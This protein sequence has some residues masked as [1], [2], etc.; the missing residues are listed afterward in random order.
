MKILNT[1]KNIVFSLFSLLAISTGAQVSI[2][3]GAPTIA[4]KGLL[5][6]QN[7]TAGIVYP[8]FELTATDIEAPVENPDGSGSS[9]PGPLFTTPI[10]QAMVLV[11][12]G[13]HRA[14]CVGR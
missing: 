12:S 5:D 3:N 13:I 10:Q 1:H 6:M 9:V 2:S 4:P 14:L 8:R 11:R 7:S